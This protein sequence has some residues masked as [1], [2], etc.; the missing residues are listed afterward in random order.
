[1]NHAVE[2]TFT[3]TNS[4]T[5]VLAITSPINASAA[6]DSGLA[7]DLATAERIDRLD[8]EALDAAVAEWV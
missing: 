5:S 8:S 7:D 3:I 6:G 1:M 2:R 4:G